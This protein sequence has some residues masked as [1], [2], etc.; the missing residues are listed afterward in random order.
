L[1]YARSGTL[2]AQRFDVG[3]LQLRGEPLPIA[4]GVGVSGVFNHA[5]YS[6]SESGLLVYNSSGIG[7]E[8]QLTWF[9]RA[10]KRLTTLGEQSSGQYRLQL[11]PDEKQLA[12][13]RMDPMGTWDVWTIDLARGIPSRFT[14][15]PS[16]DWYPV[17]SPDGGRIAF[18]SNRTG[19]YDLYRSEER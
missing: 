4:E 11:S 13:D 18:A 14:F 10:G 9:D 7:F 8:S 12:I 1:L 2:M 3:K 15:D 16:A 5:E 17:W 6:V 19:N